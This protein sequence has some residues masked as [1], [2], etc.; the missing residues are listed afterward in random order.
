MIRAFKDRQQCSARFT[1]SKAAA[2]RLLQRDHGAVSPS[3]YL[4]RVRQL[5]LLR[6]GIPLDTNLQ[7][8]VWTRGQAPPLFVYE[9]RLSVR[10]ETLVCGVLSI[11]SE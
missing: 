9:A 3:G 5:D 2:H 8:E 10:E 11:Y 7:I 4:V 1:F 6:S